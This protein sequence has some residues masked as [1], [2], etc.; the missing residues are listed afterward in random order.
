MF[1]QHLAGVVAG[2]ALAALVGL[3]S[4]RQLLL[5]LAAA[6]PGLLAE[7][8]TMQ[9]LAN[10]V[11]AAGEDWGDRVAGWFAGTGLD[12]WVIQREVA[13]PVSYVNLWLADA[14]EVS[15]PS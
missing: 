4:T 2:S 7:G 11:H 14:S 9:Y 15:M 5:L 1:G 13:D 8:G 3:G 12:A 6:A 10:W